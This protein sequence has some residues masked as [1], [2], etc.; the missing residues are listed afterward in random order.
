MLQSTHLKPAMGLPPP[1]VAPPDG[2]YLARVDYG[3]GQGGT[4]EL[5][6]FA[7][8]FLLRQYVVILLLMLLGG[9]AGAIF[10][11]VTP[12]TYIAPA[13]IL[14]GT[15]RPQFIQQQSMFADAPID[16][17]QMES[18]IQILYS[19]AIL[20]S[21]VQKLK[22]AHDPEFASPRVGLIRRL[23]QVFNNPIAAQT[24]F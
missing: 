6:D 10:L 24:N 17:A 7:L 21:V 13:Q 9:V 12:P 16:N 18:Q 22:L 20:A 23:F 2:L 19:Q 3:P 15:Q 11:V 1:P 4:G 14:I 8:G 5:I